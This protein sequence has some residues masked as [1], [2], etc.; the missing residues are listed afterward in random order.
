MPS[1]HCCRPA[2]RAKERV[3]CWKWWSRTRVN[4]LASSMKIDVLTL[5]PEMFVGPLDASMVA[6]ARRVGL[7][8][9]QSRNLRDWT[10]DRNKT[11]DDR[12]F[13]GGRG[14][15]LKRNPIFEQVEALAGKR[16]R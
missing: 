13:G 7:L 12:P 4:Q 3:V 6:R 16:T 2:A 10:P 11:V 5:F 8:D 1:G 15:V 9:L 14:T